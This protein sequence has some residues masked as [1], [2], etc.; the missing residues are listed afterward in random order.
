MHPWQF[1]WGGGSFWSWANLDGHVSNKNLKKKKKKWCTILV[2]THEILAGGGGGLSPNST[3]K[4]MPYRLDKLRSA[5]AEAR[6]KKYPLLTKY[7]F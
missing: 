4:N 7:N 1:S 2:W 3:Y 5:L 6:L